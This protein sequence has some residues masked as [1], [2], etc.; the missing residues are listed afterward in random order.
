MG[1]KL[2]RDLVLGPE[3]FDSAFRYYMH[4]WAFKHPTPYDFFHCMENAS[5]ENLDWFWRGWFLNN[6]KIDQSVSEVGYVDGDPTKGSVITINNLQKLPMPATVEVKEI[7]GK[8][9]RITLPV[10]I[11]QHGGTWKFVYPSKTQLQQ[12]TIDPD[13]VLPDVNASNNT[14]EVK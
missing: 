13:E 1:L 7:D 2:L 14:F 5:G 8:T 6:W 9:G 3:R 10:E 11:W 4:S 12:V